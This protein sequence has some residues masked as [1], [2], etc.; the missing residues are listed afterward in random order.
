MTSSFE[1]WQELPTGFLKKGYRAWDRFDHD[2]QRTIVELAK[3]QNFKCTFCSADRGLIVEHDHETDDGDR[4]TINNIRGLTC[5]R[6]NW[7]LMIYEKNERREYTGW[8]HVNCFINSSR[9][10]DY[11]Y[12]YECRLERLYEERLEKTCP[13]YWSRRILLDKFD[14]WKEGWH[15]SPYPWR[16][17]FEEIKEQRHG[18]I[19]TPGRFIK[20]LI[21]CMKFIADKVREDPE[22]RHSPEFHRCMAQLKPIVDKLRPIF[23]ARMTELGYNRSS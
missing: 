15:H 13:N 5:Q 8:D 22:F 23:E 10:D 1:R 20:Y 11:I 21:A 2:A 16:W 17:E 6:C 19:R 7:H 18:K 9:Y 14:E 12:S 4:P 3:T